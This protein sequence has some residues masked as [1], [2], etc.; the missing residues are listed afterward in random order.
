MEFLCL[1]SSLRD[2]SEEVHRAKLIFFVIV[3][4]DFHVLVSEKYDR[5]H[6]VENVTLLRQN[7]SSLFEVFD[8]LLPLLISLVVLCLVFRPTAAAYLRLHD[9]SLHGEL[10][11][12]D[13][14]CAPSQ[15][16]NGRDCVVPVVL[17]ACIRLG[18]AHV[19]LQVSRRRALAFGIARPVTLLLFFVANG[20]R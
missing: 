6:L 10:V 16:L 14:A 18:V 12:A 20:V 9:I 13:H 15:A 8:V 1:S 5:F 3:G 7:L 2:V 19:E 4:L 11:F 17:A